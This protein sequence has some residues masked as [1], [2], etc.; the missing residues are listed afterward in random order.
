M[1]RPLLIRQVPKTPFA[2]KVIECPTTSRPL[3]SM[4]D[5][6]PAPSPIRSDSVPKRVPR[7]RVLCAEVQNL[8]E[9]KT[10]PRG[11]VPD[12]YHRVP[13]PTVFEAVPIRRTR[14]AH[15]PPKVATPTEGAS[16]VKGRIRT[17][18][19][20][21]PVEEHLLVQTVFVEDHLPL[22]VVSRRRSGL[23]PHNVEKQDVDLNSVVVGNTQFVVDQV[24][25][26]LP[27]DERHILWTRSDS[28]L[29]PAGTEVKQDN[30]GKG[31]ATE[32]INGADSPS[33]VCSSPP[34]VPI[35]DFT[36][37]LVPEADDISSTSSIYGD[38]NFLPS[39][40]VSSLPNKSCQTTSLLVTPPKPLYCSS[41][42][43]TPPSP[44]GL[45]T[46]IIGPTD[47][48]PSSLSFALTRRRAWESSSPLSGGHLDRGFPD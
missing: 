14:M 2:H 8:P 42:P 28:T 20:P 31:R 36:L 29:E 27:T 30:K 44:Y 40:I 16:M 47:A 39:P 17:T 26:V 25:R 21:T 6:T 34:A 5:A 22:S 9:G 12:E 43:I 10:N 23:K 37:Q 24:D 46:G 18:K 7:H 19:I 38:E 3:T 4:K 11:M 15:G 35:H 48:G 1:P 45:R 33:N 13:G 41:D 32:D